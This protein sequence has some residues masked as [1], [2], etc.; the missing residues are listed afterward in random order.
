MLDHSKWKR[1]ESVPI[2]YRG[3]T[4]EKRSEAN[5]R[6][7]QAKL[8]SG[9]KG[10]VAMRLDVTGGTSLVGFSLVW[11]ASRGVVQDERGRDGCTCTHVVHLRRYDRAICRELSRTTSSFADK[12]DSPHRFAAMIISSFRATII[13]EIFI[14]NQS[15][16]I[17]T[18]LFFFYLKK[19]IISIYLKLKQDIITRYCEVIY[20]GYWLFSNVD[21]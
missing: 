1:K 12:T 19:Q 7:V 11:S 20:V 2:V 6:R 9:A 16:E 3:N 14:W 13:N 17:T 21:I 5:A 8:E 4:R 18:Y 10:Y 15:K